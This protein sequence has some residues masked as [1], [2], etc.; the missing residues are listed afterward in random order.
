M[1][2]EN[3][4][5]EVKPNSSS[6]HSVEGREHQVSVTSNGYQWQTISLTIEELKELN[7]TITEY[8]KERA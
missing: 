4:K 1:K 5:V 6:W 7:D 3:F 2:S 8:L